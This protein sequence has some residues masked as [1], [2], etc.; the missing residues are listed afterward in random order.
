[1]SRIGPVAFAP[2]GDVV[3]HEERNDAQRL[4]VAN[5]VGGTIARIVTPRIPSISRAAVEID[6]AHIHPLILRASFERLPEREIVRGIFAHRSD[7]N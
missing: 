5:I 6:V 3:H 7:R 4:A 1:M 2:I